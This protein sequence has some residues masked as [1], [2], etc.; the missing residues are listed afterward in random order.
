M[1]EIIPRQEAST[2]RE[3]F[4]LLNEEFDFDLDAAASNTNSQCPTYITKE[5][6]ALAA[7]TKWVGQ[8]VLRKDGSNGYA[9]SI[10]LNPSFEDFYPWM[11]KAHSEA[12]KR[13]DAVVVVLCLPSA[14]T[15]WWGTFAPMA[16]EIRDMGG[17]RVEYIPH[18]DVEFNGGN[19]RESCIMI[20]RK[21]KP[22]RPTLRWTWN[23]WDE[24]ID[25]Q[26]D[27]ALNIIDPG[28]SPRMSKKLQRIA[29]SDIASFNAKEDAVLEDS[30]KMMEDMDHAKNKSSE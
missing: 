20:F 21:D 13:L 24:L 25:H 29:E 17:R 4:W 28:H 7:D 23:W 5:A 22:G 1:K 8:L 3:L 26:R 9:R 2:P 16:S 27:D 30:F 19:S 18:P 14:S 15:K 10:F 11:Q 6:D 12:Q